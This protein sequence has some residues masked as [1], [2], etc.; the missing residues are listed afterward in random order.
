MSG[1]VSLKI[2]NELVEK[3]RIASVEQN[4]SITK[5]IEYWAKIGRIALENKDLPVSFIIKTIN[6]KKEAK[7]GEFTEF[8]FEDEGEC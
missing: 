2:S 6:A 4:R 8:K 3:A 1:G 5:Q 7:N